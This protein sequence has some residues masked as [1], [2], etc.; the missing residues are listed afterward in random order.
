MIL[1][2]YYCIGT[3]CRSQLFTIASLMTSTDS[4]LP[5]IPPPSKGLRC[6]AS[7]RLH[8]DAT[9]SL[10]LNPTE[11]QNDHFFF[12]LFLFKLFFFKTLDRTSC[13]HTY[14]AACVVYELAVLSPH[15]EWT[16]APFN[17]PPSGSVFLCCF[18]T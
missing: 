8:N 15:F 14:A 6:F 9:P 10:T 2:N 17:P 12:F 1:N 4:T 3:I 11:N 16:P 7:L 18:W 5:P 13:S